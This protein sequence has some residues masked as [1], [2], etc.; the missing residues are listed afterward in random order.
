M[1]EIQNWMEVLIH[2]ILK[3]VD[4]ERVTK[5]LARIKNAPNKIDKIHSLQDISLLV[6]IDLVFSSM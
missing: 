3:R 4:L 1:F 2:P 6:G 5:L